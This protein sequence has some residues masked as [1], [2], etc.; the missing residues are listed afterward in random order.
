MPITG[1]LEH[2]NGCRGANAQR[3]DPPSKRDRDQRIAGAGDPRP[4]PLP[5]RAEHQHE[6]PAVIDR[7]VG[8]GPLLV[9]A[10]APQVGA[11]GVGGVLAFAIGAVILV[12]PDAIGYGIPIP[13]IATLASI[14]ALFV[15]VVVRMAV[16][17]RRRPV[18]IGQLTLLDSPGEVLADFVDEGW[19]KIRGEIWRVRCARPLSTGQQVRVT[20]IDGAALDVEP[21]SIEPRG[22][23]S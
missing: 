14:S 11:L 21:Q 1:N 13:L 19:A 4:Q 3:F 16:Q 18:V 22:G 6:A 20:G 5:L 10:I 15:F 2:Q 12:D 7:G 17:A 23:T 9:G 8:L